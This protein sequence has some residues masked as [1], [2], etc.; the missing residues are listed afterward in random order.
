MKKRYWQE[1][2]TENDAGAAL[3]R[4]PRPASSRRSPS[5]FRPASELL[6]RESMPI[7]Q[8]HCCTNVVQTKLMLEM[9]MLFEL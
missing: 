2:C 9:T 4:F 6:K 1:E 3:G 7:G 8:S 5:T